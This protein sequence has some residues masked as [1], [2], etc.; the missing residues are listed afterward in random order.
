MRRAEASGMVRTVASMTEQ[1]S[2]E[3]EKVLLHLADARAR[4]RKA[5][6]A[7]EKAGAAAH[8]TAA[9]QE[10]EKQLA[11]LHRALS[12]GTYYVVPDDGLRLAV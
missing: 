8:V 2:K 7:L 9:V 1:E 11:E 6:E 4:T 12:Q 3:V 10:T 5:A